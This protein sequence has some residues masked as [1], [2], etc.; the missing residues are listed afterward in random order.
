MYIKE[1]NNTEKELWNYNKAA[2]WMTEEDY[3][4]INKNVDSEF[5][6]KKKGEF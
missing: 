5:V 2:Y 6:K 3:S 4:N 1:I